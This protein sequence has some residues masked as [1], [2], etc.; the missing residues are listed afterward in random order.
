MRWGPRRGA[1]GPARPP[2][3]PAG[4]P[5]PRT[6]RGARAGGGGAG[7]APAPARRGARLANLDP[8][9]S[10]MRC[11]PREG[12]GGAD[13]R[14]PQS[15]ARLRLAGGR[16]SRRARA[17]TRTREPSGAPAALPRAP[18]VLTNFD[19]DVVGV[20]VPRAVG[21]GEVRAVLPR[22]RVGVL[23]VRLVRVGRV[24]AELPGVLERRRAALDVGLELHGERRR[25]VLGRA[26][27][28]GEEWRGLLLA[29]TRGRGRRGRRLRRSDRG[30]GRRRLAGPST[31]SAAG[32]DE[33]E[34]QD[35]G[36]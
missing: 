5:R 22:L 13:R 24:V 21:D 12:G 3:P 4:P 8:H 23:R 6:G 31:S 33:Q 20:G 11:D 34:R 28:P 35:D 17:W 30:G 18:H 7:G 36:G 29:L 19:L 32:E 15:R 25:P 27:G 9:V 16:H 10:G 2:R 1:G 26:V 14:P